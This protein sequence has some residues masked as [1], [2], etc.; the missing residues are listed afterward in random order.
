MHLIHYQKKKLKKPQILKRSNKKKV[1]TVLK[2]Q[3]PNGR[4][5]TSFLRRVQTLHMQILIKIDIN[6]NKKELVNQF[7]DSPLKGFGR[8]T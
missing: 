5:T 6:A 3:Y 4:G 2:I 7:N 8:S 1:P